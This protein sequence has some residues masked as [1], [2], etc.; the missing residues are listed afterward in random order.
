MKNRIFI[1]ILAIL[2]LSLIIAFL[3][4]CASGPGG[5]GTPVTYYDVYVSTTGSDDAGD[6]SAAKPYKTIQKGLNSALTSEVVYVLNGVYSENVVWP[7]VYARMNLT[8]KGQSTTATTLDAGE[9]GRAIYIDLV[10]VQ[11][12]TIESMTIKKG[13]AGDGA[14]VYIKANTG[15]FK[16]KVR[17]NDLL[18]CDN[19]SSGYGGGINN[20]SDVYFV[21]ENTTFKGN[22]AKYGG[23]I[24]ALG[25]SKINNCIFDGNRASGASLSYAGALYYSGGATLTVESSVFSNNTATYDATCDG[26]AIFVDEMCYA[27]FVN[28]II[29]NNKSGRWGGGIKHTLGSPISAT[30]SYLFMTNCTIVSNE[31]G[32]T[33]SGLWLIYNNG[34]ASFEARN[35]IIWGNKTNQI[36]CTSGDENVRV[37][38]VNSDIAGG[39]YTGAINKAPNFA[40]SP[41]YDN[42]LDFKLTSNTTSEI[43]QGGTNESTPATD[44]GGFSR[45]ATKPS[46][47]AWEYIP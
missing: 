13:N 40:D 4:G 17:L 37:K 44:I 45:N 1:S 21:L 38:L 2:S 6:G 39:G 15:G 14:G 25:Y 35:S 7:T 5:G 43:S 10:D 8:L 19:T 16:Q 32:T 9:S 11:R 23:A 24:S 3:Y 26:G 20:T 28:C 12:I 47:G 30:F 42:A 36:A 18:I 46:M 29:F 34:T 31:A 27:K 22:T 33:G 41:S